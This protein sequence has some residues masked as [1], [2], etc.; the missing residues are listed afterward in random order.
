M[1]HENDGGNTE[2]VEMPTPPGGDADRHPGSPRIGT[3][4]QDP[5]PV[6]GDESGGQP[7]SGRR[8]DAGS[9]EELPGEWHEQRPISPPEGR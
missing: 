2:H 8:H 6:H 1:S 4:D 7:H 9:D 3:T 5:A